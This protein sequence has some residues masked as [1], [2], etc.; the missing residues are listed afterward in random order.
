MLL[1]LLLALVEVWI[2][3][4]S[5]SSMPTDH[6]SMLAAAA[7]GVAGGNGGADHS[8]VDA[9]VASQQIPAQS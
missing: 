4:C 3:R 1:Q 9:I 2:W 7:A 8:G 6:Q 5:N